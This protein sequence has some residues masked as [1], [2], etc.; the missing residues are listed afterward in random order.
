MI[1]ISLF[2]TPI[3][4]LVVLSSCNTYKKMVYFQTE[5]S[6]SLHVNQAEF[7]PTL[8]TDDFLSIVI[9]ADDQESA[10]PFN[11]PIMTNTYSSN[12][13]YTQGTPAKT[14]Y[15]IDDEGMVNL[16]VLG[17]THLGGK[18][19]SEATQYLENELRAYLS[20]PVVNIQIQNYKITVLGDVKRP[21]TFNIPNERI[22]LLEAIG[23]SSDLDITGMRNNVLVIREDEGQKK[24]YRI[25]LTTDEVLYSPVYY[26]QQNDVVYVEPNRAKRS[27]GTFWRSSGGILISLTSLVITTITL[28]VK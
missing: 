1:K 7:T 6:D 17:R 5:E 12:Q 4:L 16:P 25:D 21:G 27:Q 22:T 20:N 2:L 10:L 28:I 3:L 15:L 13:G 23:L 18:S 24:Q 26:L 14:G 8:K 11:F 19:R 9:T